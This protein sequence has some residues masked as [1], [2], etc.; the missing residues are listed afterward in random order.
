MCGFQQNRDRRA[1]E[2][3]PAHPELFLTCFSYQQPDLHT[4]TQEVTL[5]FLI[6][7]KQLRVTVVALGGIMRSSQRSLSCEREQHHDCNACT[8][9]Q[10]LLQ[11][12][13][14]KETA[15]LGGAI[16]SPSRQQCKG[17]RMFFALPNLQQGEHNSCMKPLTQ[18]RRLFP[19]TS[20]KVVFYKLTCCCSAQLQ[21]PDSSFKNQSELFMQL[22]RCIF[23]SF[24]S[25]ENQHFCSMF[26]GTLGTSSS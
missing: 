9:E 22:P 25:Q 11:G 4:H 1:R 24:L 18:L 19:S 16:D 20:S 23:L 3:S 7:L 5:V 26:T 13:P 12:V 14:G 17:L 8:Q 21:G 15:K 2:R 6:A 10:D